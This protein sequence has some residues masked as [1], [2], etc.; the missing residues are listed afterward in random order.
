MTPFLL[1]S[2]PWLS[3]CFLSSRLDPTEPHPLAEAAP[4]SWTAPLRPAGDLLRVED[5]TCGGG[6]AR[7]RWSRDL[8]FEMSTPRAKFGGSWRFVDGDIVYLT[9]GPI[10]EPRCTSARFVG[11]PFEALTCGEGVI[12]C[13]RDVPWAIEVLDAGAGAGAGELVARALVR[14]SEHYGAGVVIEG[15]EAPG[16]TQGVEVRY[17]LPIQ[18]GPLPREL[19]EHVADLIDRD[20]QTGPVTVQQDRSATSP[21]VVWMGGTIAEIEP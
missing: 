20:L 2:L 17:R 8:S 5:R 21:V 3:G 18:G 9:E 1:S 11:D 6:E 10:G 4:A 15:P 12:G 7:V 14:I 13:D 16:T 19:A